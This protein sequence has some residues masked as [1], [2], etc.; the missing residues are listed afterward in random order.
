MTG[1]QSEIKSLIFA[2]SMLKLI[3]RILKLFVIFF[4]G[5]TVFWVLLYRYV[6]PPFTWLMITRGFERKSDGKDWKI[7]KKWVN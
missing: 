4:I 2:A 1:Q 6:N 3:L 5:I 7:D